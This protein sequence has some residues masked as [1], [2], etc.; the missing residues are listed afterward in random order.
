[1]LEKHW[2]P[3]DT[4]YSAWNSLIN[5]CTTEIRTD[6]CISVNFFYSYSVTD[7][8]RPRCF[9]PSAPVPGLQFIGTSQTEHEPGQPWTC[10]GPC[11]PLGWSRRGT[12]CQWPQACTGWK[13]AETRERAQHLSLKPPIFVREE[14][15]SHAP[16]SWRGPHAGWRRAARWGSRD[17]WPGHRFFRWPLSLLPW[18]WLHASSP[19]RTPGKCP[20]SGRSRSWSA[21][22]PSPAWVW[23][24]QNIRWLLNICRGYKDHSHRLLFTWTWSRR[25]SRRPCRRFWTRS[26]RQSFCHQNWDS[27]CSIGWSWDAASAAPHG[28]FYTP[29]RAG[30]RPPW[31]L[32]DWLHGPWTSSKWYEKKKKKST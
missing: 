23:T 17:P 15:L 18:R 5:N 11:G 20:S 26:P 21:G 22:T 29:R 19:G 30:S 3:L 31:R 28:G 8:Q 4:M 6:S 32:Q 25:R 9:P 1:M 13:A 24:N 16:W 2:H 7:Y 27:F 10:P 12:W 14:R